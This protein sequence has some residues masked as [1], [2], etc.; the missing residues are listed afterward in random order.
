MREYVIGV[1]L[2][3]AN[4]GVAVLVGGEVI[5]TTTITTQKSDKKTKASDQL[6][7]RC[8]T[9]LGGLSGV[10]KTYPLDKVT[11]AVEVPTGSKSAAAMKSL[12]A[13]TGVLASLEFILPE[14]NFIHYTPHDIKKLIGSP[15]VKGRDRKGLNI[16]KSVELYPSAPVKRN[17][18]GSV[19]ANEEHVCDAILLAHLAG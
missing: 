5:H 4:T 7:D 1:D 19:L 2:A 9:L 15:L 11:V 3:L 10:I 13:A 18:Q 6:I 14:V 17:K 8:K 16:A 12:A